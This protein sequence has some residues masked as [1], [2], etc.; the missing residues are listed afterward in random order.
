MLTIRATS[1]V[2][3]ALAIGFA[4]AP[5]RAG[6]PCIGDA[7]ETFT[8][9]KGDCK[10]DYQAAKDAC[11][12]RDHDCVEG[13]RAGRAEC[14][15]NTSLD[16]DLATCRTNLRDAKDACRAGDPAQLDSCIDE[17]QVTAFLCRRTA[18][19]YSVRRIQS[20]HFRAISR[21]A[22]RRLYASSAPHF[23]Q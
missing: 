21:P 17:A 19:V 10:E 8:D 14:I 7:K 20:S 6:N 15:L 4:A 22:D 16:E 23:P 3:I 9:C 18:R 1:V 5:A 13:C 11:L 12:Q 2:G